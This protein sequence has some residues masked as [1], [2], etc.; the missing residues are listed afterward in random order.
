[1]NRAGFCAIRIGRV[2]TLVRPR[3]LACLTLLAL[4]ALSLLGFA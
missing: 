2:S 3:A 1:M 4:V